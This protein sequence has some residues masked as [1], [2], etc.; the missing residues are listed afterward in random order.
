[1]IGRRATRGVRA[2]W[3]AAPLLAI[4]LA[5]ACDVP[6]V[7]VQQSSATTVEAGASADASV[8]GFSG[9]LPLS[10]AALGGERD[11]GTTDDGSVAD[12]THPVDSG[13]SSTADDGA[14][15]HCASGNDP[16]AGATC[17]SSGAVCYG[18]CNKNGC[19]ACG[20][21]AWPMVCCTQ[22][23]TGTCQA[24]CKKDAGGD[25]AA[26]DG[27]TTPEAASPEGGEA[28]SAATDGALADGT[29]ADAG[30][31]DGK[32]GGDDIADETSSDT[33]ADGPAE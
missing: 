14:G 19:K 32:S 21:C 16:P 31:A 26:T 4:A 2:A 10:D 22:G 18:N 5:P 1:M 24:S 23:A 7:E 13:D 25:D 6:D 30:T 33:S 3:V 28:D 8:D 12:V 17:C 9:L 20:S 15:P 27:P 29:T 11:D